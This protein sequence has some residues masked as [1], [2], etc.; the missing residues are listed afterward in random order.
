MTINLK[1]MLYKIFKITILG[2]NEIIYN[3]S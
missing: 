3:S 2:I 1:S